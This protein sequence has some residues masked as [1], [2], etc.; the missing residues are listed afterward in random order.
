MSRLLDQLQVGWLTYGTGATSSNVLSFFTSKNITSTPTTDA[1]SRYS[2]NG[3]WEY[4][5]DQTD[6]YE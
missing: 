6:T 2:N 4:T 1:L 3:K 5:A